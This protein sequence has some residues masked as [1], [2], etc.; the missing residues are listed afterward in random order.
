M[1]TKF[2]A[3]A[4][5]AGIL[6]FFAGWLVYVMLLNGYF[7]ANTNQA[8]SRG[9]EAYIWWS[10]VGFNLTWGVLIAFILDWTKAEDFM[11]GL[12]KGAIVGFLISLTIDLQ[13]YSFMEF[14]VSK[15]TILVDVAVGT[16]FTGIIAG[17]TAFVMGKVS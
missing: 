15:T 16:A 13:F 17:I 10:L 14:F 12:M 8:L 4:L 7:E 3:G 6:S 5:T 9:K 11:A 1:S 2:V